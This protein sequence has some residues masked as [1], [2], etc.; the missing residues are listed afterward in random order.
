MSDSQF[1]VP[2]VIKVGSVLIGGDFP[3]SIQTMWKEPLTENLE[4]VAAAINT[5]ADL[6]CQI[7]RFAVPGESDAHLLGRLASM[8]DIPLVADIHFDHKIA[9]TCLDYPIAKIRINPGNIGARWKVEE[10]LQKAAGNDVPIR[11]GINSGSL[12]K[13]VRNESDIAK[14]M[15]TAAEIEIEALESFGFKNALFSLKASNGEDTIRANELFA[16]KY[17]YPLHIGLTEAGPLIGGIVKST[18]A[19]T[20]LLREGVGSTIRISLSD[21]PDT[22]VLTA[23]E[24]LLAIGLRKD[25]IKLTSCPRCGRATFDT[26]AFTDRMVRKLAAMKKNITVAVMGCA[27]NGPGEAKHADIGISG[28]GREV[29][30]FRKGSVFQTVAL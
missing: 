13:I 12:P 9:L 7:V 28:V 26:H 6:G 10:V 5:L 14:A 19:L 20:H 4:P 15:V 2:R 21:K 11:V 16:R 18:I 29:I 17:Q 23:R 25:G 22:E 8:V 24:I 1:L 27:V 3:V 30:I